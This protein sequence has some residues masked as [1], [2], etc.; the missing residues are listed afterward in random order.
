[1]VTNLARLDQ[2]WGVYFRPQMSCFK[3]IYSRCPTHRLWYLVLVLQTLSGVHRMPRTELTLGSQGLCHAC[4][5]MMEPTSRDLFLAPEG[6]RC[7]SVPA[8]VLVTQLGW[9]RN[10]VDLWGIIRSWGEA[11]SSAGFGWA[12]GRAFQGELGRDWDC[13]PG[14]EK[15][16]A[17]GEAGEGAGEPWAP[18]LMNQFPCP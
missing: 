2:K 11:M 12:V 17:G 15:P 4:G 3:C 18:Q 6:H 7:L 10:H 8:S 9:R 1:M 14:P 13:R 16:E 5:A